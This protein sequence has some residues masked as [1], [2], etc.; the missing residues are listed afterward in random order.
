M[1]SLKAR[2]NQ[3]TQGWG[4]WLKKAEVPA[5]LSNSSVLPTLPAQVILSCSSSDPA[6]LAELQNRHQAAQARTTC[7]TWKSHMAYKPWFVQPPPVIINSKTKQTNKGRVL[8]TWKDQP[9][10]QASDLGLRGALNLFEMPVFPGSC[11]KSW[12]TSSC[13]LEFICFQLSV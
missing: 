4:A 10:P 3:C 12:R 13:S 9:L 7:N 11:P 1:E 8:R 5:H 6:E 2:M